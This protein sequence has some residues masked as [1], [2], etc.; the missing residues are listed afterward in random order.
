MGAE[1]VANSATLHMA[2]WQRLGQKFHMEGNLSFHE[3][4]SLKCD[5]LTQ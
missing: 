3:Q 2:L 5:S 1:S 4:V